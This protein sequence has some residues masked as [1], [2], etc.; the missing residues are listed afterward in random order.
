M[1]GKQ[2]LLCCIPIKLTFSYSNLMAKF[3]KAVTHGRNA[4]IQKNIKLFFK[5]IHPI[6]IE[7]N[8][9]LTIHEKGRK[10]LRPSNKINNCG[11]RKRKRKYCCT[12]C[13]SPK[14]NKRTCRFA[15]ENESED[16]QECN[17]IDKINDDD[18]EE[19]NNINKEDDDEECNNI[20]GYNDDDECNNE[21]KKDDKKEECNNI[22]KY[23]DDDECNKDDERIEKSS[24]SSMDDDDAIDIITLNDMEHDNNDFLDCDNFDDLDL[25]VAAT[26]KNRKKYLSL[27]S[28]RQLEILDKY[29]IF[30]KYLWAIVEVK[31]PTDRPTINGIYYEQFQDVKNSLSRRFSDETECEILTIKLIF[32]MNFETE[33]P[34]DFIEDIRT[35]ARKFA[36]QNSSD[37]SE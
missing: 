19:C 2:K 1:I 34:L 25:E 3:S 23:S 29:P 36:N 11:A 8:A 32:E 33:I 6:N 28:E 26:L 20:D 15:T 17:N 18:D 9:P 13:H 24:D 12:R 27:L 30:E 21:N 7:G 5:N 14:H 16:L 10:T 37:E 4:E 22:D 31:D 35:M